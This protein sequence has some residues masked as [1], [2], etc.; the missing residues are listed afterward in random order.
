MRMSVQ[1]GRFGVVIAAAV[2][3]F[4]AGAARAQHAADNPITSADDAFG[5]TL[6]LE[7]V[8]IYS[9]GLVRGFS[10]ITA[11]N[12]RIDGMYFDLQ[13][14]PSNRV[15]EGSTIHV[16]I[17]EIGYAFPAPTGI[18]DY[19]LRNV[20]GDTP[21][22]TIIANVGPYE[23]WG[24]SVDGSVPLIG[25]ELVLPIGV[26]TQVSTQSP[27]GTYPGL[28]SRVSSA[29]ATPQWT[30]NA[31]V[32][33]RA[34]IDW[35]GTNN[36]KTLPEFFTAG[37]FL[38][39]SVAKG[40]IAQNW[41]KGRNTT[42]N[43]GGLVAA[44]LSDAWSLRAGVF[45]STN[46]NPISFGDFYTDVQST[47]QS[48]HLVVGYPDQSTS[49]TSGEIR[50][51]GTF[52]TGD[53]RHQLIFMTRGRDTT[54]RYGGE[55]AVDVGPAAIGTIVQVPEP[56][57]IYSARARDHAELWSIGAAYR[58]DWRSQGVLEMGIQKEGYSETVVSPGTPE[59]EVTAHPFRAYTNGAFAVT[60]QLTFYAGYTQGLENSGVAP[61]SAQ[62][63]GSVL[64]ASLTWQ[65]DSGARYAVTPKLKIIAGVFELQKPYFN[66]DTNNV[67][68]ELGVQQAR[69]IELSVAGEVTEDFHVNVGVLDGRVGITGPNLAAEGV[70]SVAVGQPRLMYVANANYSLPW[71]E[72]ASLDVSATHFG[73]APESVD[74]GVF[75]PAATFMSVGGRY[76]FTAFGENSML[77]LQ[78]Q[79]V[80]QSK[81]WS[82]VYTPGFFQWPGPR[83]VFAY[84]TT[85]LQ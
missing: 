58:L 78:V 63:S 5:L 25:K 44:Q 72:A 29:G 26:S 41:A 28:T 47:G 19:N 39:P 15:I 48:E 59:S 53:W 37:D 4:Q 23:A 2:V 27:Y 33:V 46:D 80:L 11:G 13:G 71:W 12:V 56:D 34:L 67:D 3:T 8:G 7:S 74:D 84:I 31:K 43:L 36:A 9:P 17:S 69:G 1:G 20:G 45:R 54:S 76:K 77:R 79:N 62:N 70:G 61:N 50:L 38:P 83:T 22:A 21:T 51:T 64:P 16:G 52:T 40:Y 49:S 32:T 55:D 85:D 6:G 14:A 68:R 81:I 60:P 24:I 18:A 10:P 30:P 35:Q 82:S 57:F 73:T 42:M 66:L 65:V 75:T